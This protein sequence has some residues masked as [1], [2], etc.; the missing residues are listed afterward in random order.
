MEKLD[1]FI[2]NKI[3]K[4]F[5]IAILII[6]IFSIVLFYLKIEPEWLGYIGNIIG[7]VMSSAVTFFVL[8]ITIKEDYE[9]IQE[10]FKNHDIDMAN[11]V[12]PVIKVCRTIDKIGYDL[13]FGLGLDNRIGQIMK[14]HIIIKNIGTGPARN[15]KIKSKEI[16]AKYF[17]GGI[18]CFD[19]GVNESI[20]AELIIAGDMSVENNN[21]KYINF[22][23]EYMDIYRKRKY[24]SCIRA[25][26][27][28]S[29]NRYYLYEIVD[30][31]IIILS[32]NDN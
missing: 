29:N 2:K 15:I 28:N 16:Y 9:A 13:H 19:L 24:I 23:I 11:S 7:I 8:Y 22:E 30:E 3:V 32:E 18:V 25:Y 27:P 10:N 31:K 21:V 12:M 14:L 6:V 1:K 4:I 26:S 20:D 17:K 5:A